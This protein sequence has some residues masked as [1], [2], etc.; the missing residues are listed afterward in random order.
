MRL[1]ISSELV[2]RAR[3]GE[4]AAIDSL[5]GALWPHLYRIARS[6]LRDEALA[7]DAAQEACAHIYL[8]LPKLRNAHAFQAWFYRIISREAI[9]VAKRDTGFPT[10][11]LSPSTAV[12]DS[13]VH[14]DVVR[15]LG[16]LPLDLRVAVLLY[17]YAGL[18]SSEIG[19]ALRIPNATV[20]F[21]LGR[22]RRRLQEI[23]Q[24]EVRWEK[25][26]C[27]D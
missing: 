20:R 1:A 9:R 25:E 24:P 10:L 27:Y 13:D 19:A 17:Y 7:Q 12:T 4:A 5:L 2:E 8:S 18:N 26:A 11:E 22:A 16:F 15:A 6:I 14:L 21:R 23:L 3:N